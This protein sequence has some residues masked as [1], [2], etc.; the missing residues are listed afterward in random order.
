MAAHAHAMASMAA[1]LDAAYRRRLRIPP[2]VPLPPDGATLRRLVEAHLRFVPFENLSFHTAG[3]ADGDGPPPPLAAPAVP[4]ALSLPLLRD[5]ILRRRRGG[6]CLELNGL[7]GHYLLEL[8][9]DPVRLVPCWVYA[10]PERGHGKTKT[11]TKTKNSG[12]SGGQK[13]KFRTRQTHAFLLV[14]TPDAC[15][16][17]RACATGGGGGGGDSNG[18]ADA[19]SFLVD[20]GF[21]EPPL[22][23]LRYG[24]D[25]LGVAQRTP[26]GMQSRI[27][28][29]SQD[30]TDGQGRVRRCLRLEWWRPCRACL[31]RGGGDAAAATDIG[32]D[33]D[34]DDDDDL[35]LELEQEAKLLRSQADRAWRKTKAKPRPPFK[36][37]AS[38]P[39]VREEAKG[40]LSAARPQG[41]GDHG[42][43]TVAAIASDHG[44][45]REVCSMWATLSSAERGVYKDMAR[46]EI[47]ELKRQAESAEEKAKNAEA[48]LL[49][50]V[51][52]RGGT[53]FTNGRSSILRCNEH[54]TGEGGWWEPRLQWDVSDAP[55][56]PRDGERSFVV[57]RPLESFADAAAIVA[58]EGSTFL[59]KIV[60]C[61]LTRTAK[62]TL[63]GHSLRVT[64]PRFPT[65]F[66]QEAS[67]DVGKMWPVQTRKELSSKEDILST[68]AD[69]FDLDLKQFSDLNLGDFSLAGDECRL[70]EHL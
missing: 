31:A 58:S 49:D 65:P 51:T 69:C 5:K 54:C 56:E 47:A 63:T 18:D 62:I 26:D 30:W 57:D 25:A 38:D 41:Q 55:L 6:I 68:L 21:G 53:E 45:R 36:V 39:F 29:E 37:F 11:K 61:V 52:R 16:S 28:P 17:S 42:E 50:A 60:V 27:V 66:P 59:S 3:T 64:S 7:L 12:G 22:H 4:V 43:G 9:Y 14:R 13:A 10:G 2:S 15:T 70:W 33:D 8:G 44:M 19:G 34:D 1:P 46:A 24:P 67:D 40:R 23:P 35:A 32:H 48:S 20:V